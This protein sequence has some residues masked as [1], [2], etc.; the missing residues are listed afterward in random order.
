MYL[1]VLVYGN[2]ENSG[3]HRD[4]WTNVGTEGSTSGSTFVVLQ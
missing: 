2:K 3:A 1:E 4:R